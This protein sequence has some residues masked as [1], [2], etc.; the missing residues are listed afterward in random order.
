MVWCSQLFKNFS[1]FALIHIVKGFSIVNEA[2]VDIFLRFFCFF[3]VS[4]DVGNLISCSSDL[5]KYSL[6]A[7]KFSVHVLLKHSFEDFEHDLD[8]MGN[9]HS[10]ALPFFQIGMKTDLF[11]SCGHC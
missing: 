5:S 9:D 2:E 6:Y 10:L 11:Q 3:Y 8:S 4:A 1:Q 7:W